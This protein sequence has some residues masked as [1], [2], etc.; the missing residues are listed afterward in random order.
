MGSER[1][2]MRKRQMSVQQETPGAAQAQ[3]DAGNRA[4]NACC[5]CWCCCCSCSCLT[6]RNEEGEERDRRDSHDVKT[7]STTNCEER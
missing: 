2:E 4:S 5:F 3:P 1:M 6:V 7:D